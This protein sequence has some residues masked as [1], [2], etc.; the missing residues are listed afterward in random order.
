MGQGF[1]CEDQR[2]HLTVDPV[3]AASEQACFAFNYR[4]IEP[5]CVSLAVLNLSDHGGENIDP[6]I[7]SLFFEICRISC[8]LRNDDMEKQTQ[9]TTESIV[10]DWLPYY[11]AIQKRKFS[12]RAGYSKMSGYQT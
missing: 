10:Y 5:L 7:Q 6:C 1:L 9:N 3:F 8:T 11:K 12:S 2:I 4:E